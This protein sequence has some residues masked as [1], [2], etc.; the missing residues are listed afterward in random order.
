M[1]IA[2]IVLNVLLFFVLFAVFHSAIS[3][4]MG[5]KSLHSFGV[6]IQSVNE[7]EMPYIIVFAIYCIGSG[8]SLFFNVKKQYT[9]SYVISCVM[10]LAYLFAPFFGFNW[11]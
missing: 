9:L 6:P 7:W 5:Y 8:F 4:Y 3:L 1:K 10:V 11:L 2:S